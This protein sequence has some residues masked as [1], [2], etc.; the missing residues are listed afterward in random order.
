MYLRSYLLHVFLLISS[1]LRYISPRIR[2]FLLPAGINYNIHINSISCFSSLF[3]HPYYSSHPAS[4][5]PYSSFAENPPIPFLSI[6]ILYSI[7]TVHL[8]PANKLRQTPSVYF[9]PFGNEPETLQ[10]QQIVQFSQIL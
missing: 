4:L 8:I 3:Y 6:P 10:A 1:F 5:K 9:L 2:S 7:P